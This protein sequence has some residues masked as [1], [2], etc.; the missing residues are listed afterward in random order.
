M[1]TAI[2][3]GHG[4]YFFANRYRI[5]NDVK[6]TAWGNSDTELSTVHC[7][8][9]VEGMEVLSPEE[10]KARENEFDQIWIGTDYHFADEIYDI[11]CQ[12]GVDK[13]KIRA[14]CWNIVD[15]RL[16]GDIHL[17]GYLPWK[18]HKHRQLYQA[19]EQNTLVDRTRCYELYMSVQQSA[20]CAEGDLLEVGVWRG[21]TGALIASAAADAGLS[22][23]VYLADTFEGCVKITDKDPIYQGGEH[24]DT[25]EETVRQ[26]IS[27]MGLKNVEIIRGI[28]PD[29]CKERLCNVK[30]R[31]VH[32]DVDVYQ[33][34]KDIFED[35]WPKL[36]QGG[37]V[38]FDDY[39]TLDTGGI[40]SCCDELAEQ[41]QDAVFTYNLNGHGIFVKVAN[42]EATH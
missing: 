5:P 25:S 22:A 17:Y 23:T 19:I 20:K 21:G 24:S 8:K 13:N 30:L 10:I 31:F 4:Q 16:Y 42:G 35:I 1:K 33:S 3:Y 38:V 14:L 29:D 9:L 11:L 12:H 15:Q 6:I 37:I 36:V 39:G 32:I 7:G 40:T 18:Q 2:V 41:Y 28:Y 34:A 26:L 27:E